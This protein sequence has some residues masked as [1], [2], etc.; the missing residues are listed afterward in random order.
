[1]MTV[2]SD[3]KVTR[4]FPPPAAPGGSRVW[5]QVPASCGLGWAVTEAGATRLHARLPPRKAIRQDATTQSR[6]IRRT[7][8]APLFVTGAVVTAAAWQASLRGSTAG[9]LASPVPG[10]AIAGS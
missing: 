8:V 5:S 4:A 9:D 6:I 10:D 1:M 7:T 2:P 3:E